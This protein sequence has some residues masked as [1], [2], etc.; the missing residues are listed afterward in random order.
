MARR[1]QSW[2]ATGLLLALAVLYTWATWRFFTSQL[3]GGNDFVN[4]A[5]AWEPF[6]KDGTS[7]YSDEAALYTQQVLR[8]RPALPGEDEN[9]MVYP[10]YSIILHGP[11]AFL[12]YAV[13]RAIYMTLL[14]A[15]LLAG[16]AMTMELVRW[17]PRGWLLG[18]VL[19]WVLLYYPQ[20]RGIILGQFAILG[21][22]S[23]AGTLYL[24][25]RQQELAAGALLVL[26]TVKPPLV[27]LIVPFL[28]LWGATHGRWRFVG[29]FVG[30][31]ALLTAGSLLALPT[32]ISEWWMRIR[33]Y[34]D[35]TVGQ[36]P[37]WLLTH[38]AWP[39]L[40]SAGELALAAVLAAG[41]L[42]AWWQ[43]LRPGG[44]CRFHW[45]LGVTLVISNLI[46]PRSATTNYVLMLVPTLW[47]LAALDRAGRA[48]RLTMLVAMLTSLVGMWWLHFA[49]VVGNQEQAIM[50]IP[51]PLLLGLAM[52]A[53][54]RWL[55]RDAESMGV[56]P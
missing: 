18:L 40:G 43:A 38:L 35:Y 46:V 11:F 6:F 41:M 55:L 22:F 42:A 5:T 37:V 24:L 32:W 8:G 49:T 12:D 15:A 56:R 13:G 2:F 27:F 29:G 47:L 33:M 21:F 48:G 10:F 16:A 9:R 7:P 30:T 31:L 28:L 1:H 51:P 4:H 39:E 53:G 14:Q 3:P 25:R 23:L 26:A 44:D 20:A 45:A 36:S 50:F 19:A 34:S 52:L 17:R 54:R